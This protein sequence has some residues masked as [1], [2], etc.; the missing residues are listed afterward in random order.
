[1][2]FECGVFVG[3]QTLGAPPQRSKAFLLLEAEP[4]RHQ[5]TLSDAAGLDPRVHHNNPDE[6]VA[7]ARDFL[8]A[9]ISPRPLGTAHLL[10]LY[11]EFETA[12]PELAHRFGHEPEQLRALATFA[13]WRWI[14]ATWLAERAAVR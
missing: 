7:C 13:D 11:S 6:L 8:A 4:H 10:A 3:A 2:P 1:M 9:H 5:K 12:Y 14:A